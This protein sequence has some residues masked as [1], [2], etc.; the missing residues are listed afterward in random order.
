MN[1]R[2]P[3]LKTYQII[4]LSLSLLLVIACIVATIVC[5]PSL[6][7]KIPTHYG[8]DGSVDN[9]GGKSSAFILPIMNL[10]LFIIFVFILFSPRVL[11]KPNTL[12]P[13]DM[14]FRAQ[15]IQQSQSLM[16]ECAFICTLLL[17]YI[18]VFTLIQKPLNTV[19]AWIIACALL[20]DSLVRT[21]TL[22][23]F[24]IKQTEK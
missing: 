19:G 18:Q 12:R 20:A 5:Y 24:T 15:I 17:T 13:L 4:L 14:R 21:V 10:V 3:K 11:E 22:S 8:G 9:Y 1:L 7:D 2:I 16:V 6:P 23:K